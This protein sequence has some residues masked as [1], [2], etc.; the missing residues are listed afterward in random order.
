MT[1]LRV[2]GND[3]DLCIPPVPRASRWSGTLIGEPCA[4][5]LDGVGWMPGPLQ[6]EDDC[7]LTGSDWPFVGVIG[8]CVLFWVFLVLLLVA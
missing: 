8:I 5:G 4:M 3:A 1:A 7:G 2:L 6:E